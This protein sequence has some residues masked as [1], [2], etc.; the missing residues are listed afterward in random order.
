MPAFLGMFTTSQAVIGLGT[1]YSN[2]A[3]SFTVM[4]MLG[5]VFE[6]LFQSVG[7][8]KTTMASM[9]CGCVANILLDPR[10]G[11]FVIRIGD[12]CFY[13]PTPAYAET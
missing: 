11:E 1:R 2:V 6:K 7:A 13:N 4:I 3:F 8:M 5:L 12:H 9:L 10:V